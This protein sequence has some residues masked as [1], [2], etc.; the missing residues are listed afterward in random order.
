MFL[1]KDL[2]YIFI[3]CIFL[4]IK[5]DALSCR[6]CK[7]LFTKC[8]D[9]PSNCTGGL[10]KDV[11]DCCKICAKVKGE[12]CGGIYN[13]LGKCDKGLMC[14]LKDPKDAN[15][16]GTC[17]KSYYKVAKYILHI[18]YSM[19]NMSKCLLGYYIGNGYS[20]ET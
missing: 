11:C 2:F 12:V 3:F 15:S 14:D 5:V 7:T 16:M 6:P 10:V 9:P 19:I 4:K 17:I 13:Y 18:F 8:V 1:S 20:I